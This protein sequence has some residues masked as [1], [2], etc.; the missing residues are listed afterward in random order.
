VFDGG[1]VKCVNDA[2]ISFRGCAKGEDIDLMFYEGMESS[3]AQ[4]LSELIRSSVAS[5]LSFFE[6]F[7][8]KDCNGNERSMRFCVDPDKNNPE[9]TVFGLAYDVTAE[10]ELSMAKSESARF[11][12]D[13][14]ASGVELKH[15]QKEITELKS[16]SVKARSIP[17]LLPLGIVL[18]GRDGRVTYTNAAASQIVGT[19]LGSFEMVEDWLSQVVR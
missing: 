19:D 4:N 18:L 14:V 8:V 17:D 6:V 9:K 11:E 3:D 10:D 1:S 13:L 16:S 15:A 2:W 12:A 5:R 7:K